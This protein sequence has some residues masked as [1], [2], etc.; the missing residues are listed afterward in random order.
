MIASVYQEILTR[1]K[2]STGFALHS[3]EIG[4]PMNEQEITEW[5]QCI[6]GYFVLVQ[7]YLFCMELHTSIDI[8][9]L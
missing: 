6:G 3:S 7:T 8:K 9:H 4:P 1:K 2:S 5:Q